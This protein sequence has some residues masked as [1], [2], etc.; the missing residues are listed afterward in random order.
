M[1]IYGSRHPRSGRLGGL[2]R[3]ISLSVKSG[4]VSVSAETETR[5]G[6]A[7]SEC[8]TSPRNTGCDDNARASRR[9]TNKHKAST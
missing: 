4:T 1:R 8:A 7:S 9:R 3:A 6:P 2:W 5:I